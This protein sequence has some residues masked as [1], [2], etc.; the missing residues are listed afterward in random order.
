VKE[1]GRNKKTVLFVFLFC[2]LL[3][4]GC[5][6]QKELPLPSS[7]KT[8]DIQNVIHIPFPYF[9][10]TSAKGEGWVL[11]RDTN[12]SSIV[13]VL[14]DGKAVATFP[15]NETESQRVNEKI[16]LGGHEYCVIKITAYN[17]NVSGIVTLKQLK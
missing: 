14:S 2:M 3:I 5:S 7:A 11:S 10:T 6:N 16:T 15:V 17:D 1:M 8:T 4:I 12:G 13:Q 9:E